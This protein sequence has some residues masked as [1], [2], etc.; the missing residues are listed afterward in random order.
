MAPQREWFDT[1]YYKVLGVAQVGD[2][3]GHLQ[4]A[5]AS[6]PSSYHPGSP[7]RVR[8]RS[9]KRSARPTTCC[10]D[11]PKAQGVRR[12]PSHGSRRAT[13]SPEAVTSGPGFDH[14]GTFPRWTTCSVTCSGASSGG[15]TAARR[16][17]EFRAGPAARRGES[18]VETSA[19]SVVQ[20]RGQGWVTTTVNRIPRR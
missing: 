12:G 19:A 14:A 7:T 13:R 17:P 6:W 20:R 5:T 11:A 16:R 4:G 10:G 15:V 8:R 2:G 3:Q 1:D 9:S 18:D